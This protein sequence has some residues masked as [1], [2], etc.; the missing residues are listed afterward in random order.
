MHLELYDILRLITIFLFLFF[1]FFLLQHKKGKTLSNR[2]FSIFLISKACCY[3]DSILTDHWDKIAAWSLHFLYMGKSF[4][5]LLGPSL[6]FYILSLAYKDFK[7]KKIHLLHLVPF[8]LHWVLMAPRYYIHGFESKLELFS[9]TLPEDLLT[10]VIFPILIYLHFIFYSAISLYV[11][12]RYR[13]RLKNIYSTV[14]HTQLYWLSAVAAGFIFIWGAALGNFLLDLGGEAPLVSKSLTITGIFIFANFIVYRGLKYPEIFS[15][16]EEEEQVDKEEEDNTAAQKYLKTLLPQHAQEKY[17]K[18]LLHYM[19]AEKPYL[20]PN[21]SIK[22]ISK[23]ISI[24][25]YFISQ[26]INSRLKKNF[27]HFVNDYRIDE[28]KQLL[29]DKK[30]TGRSILDIL[31]D[32]G[33]NSKSTF[34]KAFKKATGMTPSQFKRVTGEEM[35][36]N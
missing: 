12:H 7:F 22:D 24:P 15:G 35:L 19:E 29:K 30:N 13:S 3:F 36:Y 20:D 17:L 16:I 8:F 10:G 21:L 27:F 18:T 1:A 28:S 14:E 23:N 26:V 25:S 11:L 31:Y 6:Y 5:F 33:F 4:E 32:C 2:I 34:N 9:T